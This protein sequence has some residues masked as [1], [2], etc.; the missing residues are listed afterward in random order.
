[1]ISCFTIT[2]V[3]IVTCRA[4]FVFSPAELKLSLT[5]VVDKV[6]VRLVGR[7]RGH[8][9]PVTFVGAERLGVAPP[10]AGGGDAVGLRRH[11]V[12]Q[13]VVQVA[14]EQAALVLGGRRRAAIAVGRV[15]HGED[16]APFLERA[17][18]GR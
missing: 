2:D 8:G 17:L 1:M 11:H 18:V 15:G 4:D 5:H 14:I 10:L 12:P 13:G 3:N 6:C 16:T 9:I 7:G